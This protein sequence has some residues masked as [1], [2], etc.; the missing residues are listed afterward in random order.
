MGREEGRIVRRCVCSRV[1]SLRHL[2]TCMSLSPAC[3][4]PPW[5][6]PAVAAAI[7][8]MDATLSK[9]LLAQLIVPNSSPASP[10][11][12]L[13]RSLSGS[14]GDAPPESPE[15]VSTPGRLYSG[16]EGT[17]AA[18]G[19]IVP[20]SCGGRGGGGAGAGNAAFDAGTAVE[21]RRTK[22]HFLAI[23]D[24]KGWGQ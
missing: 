6:S 14:S 10:H 1:V 22:Q 3:C 19:T 4:L 23:L 16:S 24:S 15:V 7:E 5:P 2:L 20:Y 13:D 17:G 11:G 18:Q 12:G 8:A 9:A 21:V